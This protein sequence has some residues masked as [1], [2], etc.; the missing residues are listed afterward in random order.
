[1]YIC[2]C[3]CVRV[4]LQPGG[5]NVPGGQMT[6][7]GPGGGMDVRPPPGMTAGHPVM[8]PLPVQQRLPHPGAGPGGPGG[9]GGRLPGPPP[10]SYGSVR[11]GGLPPP[12]AQLQPGPP[13]PWMP[14]VSAVQLQPAYS[15]ASPVTFNNGP[16]PAGPGTPG[17][18]PSPQDS[19]ASGESLYGSG[20]WWWPSPTATAWP[21]TTW[22]P[23]SLHDRR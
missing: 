2:I 10:G 7:P 20:R 19:T 9:A 6:V 3:V 16:P 22:T 13:R 15:A 11:P 8:G 4:F 1:M 23:T 5:V 14:P 12:N 21:R 18:M 17:V